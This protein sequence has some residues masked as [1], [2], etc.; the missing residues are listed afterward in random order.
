MKEKYF[1]I[2]ALYVP[3][4][5]ALLMFR[6]PSPTIYLLML[7]TSSLYHLFTPFSFH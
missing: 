5:E 3:S 7:A 1:K 4:I 6:F 2:L